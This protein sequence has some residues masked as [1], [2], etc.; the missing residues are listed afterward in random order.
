MMALKLKE[1][2][3]RNRGLWIFAGAGL[4]V[5]VLL[6]VFVSPWASSSPDGLEKVARDKGFA[7]KAEDTQP[8]WK[9]SPLKDYSVS[10]VRNEKA[11]T[12]IS[13]LLGVLIT[14]SFAVLVGLF[15]WGLGVRKRNREDAARSGP[16]G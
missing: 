5:A 8:A 3:S 14:V 9:H 2:F 16:A 11:S 12:G 15:A 13:G 1:S 7:K 10:G 4:L 6:A